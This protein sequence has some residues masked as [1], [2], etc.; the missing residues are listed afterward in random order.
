MTLRRLVKTVG[1]NGLHAAGADRLIG[2]LSKRGGRR[3]LV[4]CYHRVVEDVRE[5]P[6][7]APAMLVS[8]GTLEAQLDWVGRRY[9]FVGLDEI[10]RSLEAGDGGRGRSGRPMAAV[11]F[12]D[13]YSDVYHHA[14][15]L[16]RRMGIPATVFVVTGIV[17]SGGLHAHDEVYVL[18]DRL[19]AREG[20]GRVVRRLQALGVD[21]RRFRP[22]RSGPSHRLA[23]LVEHLLRSLPRRELRRLLAALRREVSVPAALARELRPMSWPMLVALHGAG[24]TI[25][26]H[27]RSHPILPNETPETI[28]AELAG[29]KRALEERLG[30]EVVHL[31]YPDGQFCPTTV[32]AA[33]DAGY[34]Y[35]FTCCS[36]AFAGQPLLTIPRRAFWERSSVGLSGRFSP[37]IAACQVEG[38]LELARPCRLDHR[39]RRPR[40]AAGSGSERS[41]PPGV[42]P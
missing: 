38:V 42:S 9:D 23:E 26:S 1:A 19:R 30:G 2:R 5:H 34:R 10:C 22:R 40:A 32:E 25:G 39:G 6:L 13:G 11:T 3:P 7:S 15:P 31:A 36:H 41:N 35:A 17:D 16:L 37:A 4:L 20:G 29:S 33:R 14:F 24:V 12:D 18:L 28:R 8:V 21:A 27:T